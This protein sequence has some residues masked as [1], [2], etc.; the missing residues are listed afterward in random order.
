MDVTATISPIFTT[1]KRYLLLPQKNNTL[2]R[3]DLA[4][5]QQHPINLKLPHHC[6]G[7]SAF[8]L[9]PDGV[10]IALGHQCNV[11][12]EPADLITY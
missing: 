7:P 3:F 10:W 8:D 1:N 5:R 9:S 11:G 2:I 4:T 6:N 12:S